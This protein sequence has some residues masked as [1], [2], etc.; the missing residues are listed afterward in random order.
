MHTAY[1]LSVGITN[2]NPNC[3]RIFNFNSLILPNNRLHV[4]N[5]LVYSTKDDA[6][7]LIKYNVTIN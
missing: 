4:T 3:N 2:T 5:V 1:H 6:D 7:N